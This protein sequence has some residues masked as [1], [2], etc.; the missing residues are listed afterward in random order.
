MKKCKFCGAELPEEAQFCPFCEKELIEKKP[1]EAPRPRRRRVILALLSALALLL[2]LALSTGGLGLLRRGVPPEEPAEQEVPAEQAEP[3]KPEGKVYN[4]GAPA[5]DMQYTAEDGVNYRIF[6]TCAE[7]AEAAEPCERITFPNPGDEEARAVSLLCA[8]PEG[9]TL[10]DG[11]AFGEL[12][13]KVDLRVGDRENAAVVFERYDV[14]HDAD[15]PF[16]AAAVTLEYDEGWG[17][18]ELLWIVRMKNGDVLYLHQL[19]YVEKGPQIYNFG[20]PAYD[21]EYTA[22]DDVR[23]RLFLTFVNKDVDAGPSEIFFLPAPKNTAGQVVSK[24]CAQPEGGKLWDGAAFGDLI[25]QVDV[26]VADQNGAMSGASLTGCRSS[27]ASPS[28][29][30]R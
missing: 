24:L 14:P 6:L 16:A 28:P 10:A 15:R 11:A 3:A 19:V 13:E 23:Y 30:R 7:T 26:R 2:I 21:M 12:I 1:L 22:E 18:D 9:G 29:R 25:E 8:V 4:A 17:K 20:A 5:F 27:R